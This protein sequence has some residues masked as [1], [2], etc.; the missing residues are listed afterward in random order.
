MKKYFEFIKKYSLLTVFW[1]FIIGLS[2]VN[3]CSKSADFSE[4]ENRYLQKRPQFTLKNF[5]KGNFSQKYEEFINDQFVFRNFWINTKMIS[6]VLLM[7]IEN[8]G[9]II[10]KNNYLFDK[11]INIDE[12][13]AKDNLVSVL[14]FV[15]NNKSKNIYFSIIPNSY[16]VLQDKLPINLNNI[17]QKKYIDGFYKMLL[18]SNF[19]NINIIDS[20][21]F[22]LN[23]KDK[24]Y[25]CLD[26][27]WTT[28]GAYYFYRGLASILNYRA[29]NFNFLKEQE[30]KN[31]YGTYYSRAKIF[32][33]KPDT[34]F[35]YNSDENFIKIDG[36][37]YKS[38]YDKEKFSK[39]DK[40]AGFLY[41]NH[42]LLEIDS[43]NSKDKKFKDKKEN[44]CIIKDSYANSLIPFL[45]Y[46]YNKIYVIDLRYINFNDLH[47]FFN[48]HDINDVLILYNF[49]NF[50][51]DSNINKLD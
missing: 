46:N 44:I 8:N 12:G 16:A 32:W 4:I 25:Y 41:G 42:G 34:I 11:L 33:K 23:K 45:T 2:L 21:D 22:L 14:N 20:F 49:I 17:N 1:F 30:V 10:G 7:K 28:K 35:Y 39:R 9:I 15:S 29:I 6:E 19:Q 24:I 38:I 50:V 47:K 31:F 48:E 36:K 26:H 13:R 43:R 37:I 40:Y 3:L 51:S 18:N 5:I 27:H